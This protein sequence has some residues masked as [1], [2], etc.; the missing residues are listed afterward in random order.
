MIFMAEYEG[1]MN[2]E[3]MAILHAAYSLGI[4]ESLIEIYPVGRFAMSK[5]HLRL[6]PPKIEDGKLIIT[7]TEGVFIMHNND[8]GIVFA[9]S[10]GGKHKRY[11]LTC[12]GDGR[13]FL[14]TIRNKHQ[15]VDDAERW[16]RKKGQ[17]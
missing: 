5:D 1:S 11:Y 3:E 10:H 13:P 7:N 6:T 9:V 14:R 8:D 2:V 15:S 16:L 17:L 4:R 12:I